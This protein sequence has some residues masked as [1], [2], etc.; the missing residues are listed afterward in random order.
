MVLEQILN[1]KSVEKRSLNVFL[2]GVIYSFMG[3]LCAQVIF[4]DNVGT[5][6]IAFISV[7]L[8]PSLSFMLQV[9][10]NVEIRENKL[11]LR[12]LFKDHKDIFKL[13]I[14]LFLAIFFSYALTAL[15]WEPA[16]IQTFFRPQLESAGISGNAVLPGAFL[17]IVLNNFIILFLSFV[18]SIIYGSGA[19]LFITWNASVWGIVL[20]FFARYAANIG[21]KSIFVY[22]VE[23]LVPFLPHMVTEATSYISAAIVGGV[24]SKAVIREKLFS[25]KFHH[26]VTDAFMLLGLAVVL[27]VVA[28]CIEFCVA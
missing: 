28:A 9:E 22:F 12:L 14:V 25:K 4:P 2:L 20:G 19:V 10:E 5:M 26:I 3:I 13:Y 23:E 1:L 8:I 15:L 11:S 16:V 27:I 21:H 17:G 6:S 7:L 24:V 18:L